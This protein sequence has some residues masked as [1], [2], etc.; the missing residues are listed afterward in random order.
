MCDTNVHNLDLDKHTVHTTQKNGTEGIMMTPHCA[1]VQLQTCACMAAA[2]SNTAVL[3]LQ[4][5][6]LNGRCT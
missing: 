1:Q 5:E 3:L 6:T 2:C 4:H